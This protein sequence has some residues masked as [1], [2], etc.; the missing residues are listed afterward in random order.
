MADNLTKLQ[1]ALN[2]NQRRIAEARYQF[3]LVS[4]VMSDGAIM[5]SCVSIFDPRFRFAVVWLYEFE[6]EQF[7][8]MLSQM[9]ALFADPD[10]DLE[11]IARERTEALESFVQSLR[12]DP[13]VGEQMA[14][15]EAERDEFF[16]DMPTPPPYVV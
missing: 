14:A 1:A 5:V 2:M 6:Q 10:F 13:E 4:E 12:D 8:A 3:V 11:K 16:R 9:S 15:F 7:D